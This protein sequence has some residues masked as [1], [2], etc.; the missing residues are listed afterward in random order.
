MKPKPW[1]TEIPIGG[2]QGYMV[3]ITTRGRLEIR[4]YGGPRS[5]MNIKEA[6]LLISFIQTGID[7]RRTFLRRLRSKRKVS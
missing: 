3:I 6:E 4:E 7:L 2:T 5:D 1:P